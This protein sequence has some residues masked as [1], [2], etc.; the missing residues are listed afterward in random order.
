MTSSKTRRYVKETYEHTCQFCYQQFPANQFQIHHI[1]RRR[2]GGT[3]DPQNL[4]S[5]CESCHI[6]VHNGN[7][8]HNSRGERI[9]YI[10]HRT[11][12]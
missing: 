10:V 2:D 12:I 5:L 11:V 1:L 4:V 9:M 7:Y 3:D 6:A 8:T